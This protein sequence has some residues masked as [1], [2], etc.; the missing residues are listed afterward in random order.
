MKMAEK[1]GCPIIPVTLN[2]T[3]NIF[4]NQFPKIRPVHVVLE[5]GA[6]IDLKSL[7][8]EERQHVGSYTRDIILATFE[9]NEALV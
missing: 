8:K 7:S 2:N 6:P 9:K 5:Y 3:A 1:T 4:E